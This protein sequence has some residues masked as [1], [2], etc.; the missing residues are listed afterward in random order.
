MHIKFKY[1]LYSALV[2]AMFTS[3]DDQD[4][5]SNKQASEITFVSGLNTRLSQDGGQWVA[6]DQIGIYMVNTGTTTATDYSN[7]PYKAESSAQTTAF[8]A[9]DASIYY[10]TDQS[11][12]D[13]IAYYP[14]AA[15]ITNWTYPVSL[16]NQSTGSAA[17]DLLYAKADN[18]GSGFT[19]GSVSFAFNHSLSKIILN[20]VDEDNKP[21]TPD[22]DGVR[23]KGMNTTADFDLKTGTLGTAATVADIAPYASESAFHAV[24]L[25]TTIASGHEVAIVVEGNPYR[26]NMNSSHSG[27][28]MKAGS[29]YTFKV[30]VKTSAAEVEAVLVDYSD[31]SITPWGDGGADNKEE[32]PTADLDIPA[33]YEKLELQNGES[34]KSALAGATGAKV[35]IVLADGGSY[36]ESGG[37]SIPAS[38]TSLIIAGKGG[39]SMP[40]VNFGGTM[41]LSGNMDLFKVYN[42]D[43]SGVYGSS[44]FINQSTAV[45]IGEI[46]FESCVIH[47]IRG[48]IRLQKEA[49]TLNLYKITDCIIYNINNYSLLAVEAE[50]IAPNV[51]M[52]KSTVYNVSGR[53]FNISGTT[54]PSKATIDQCTFN[55]GPKYAIVQFSSTEGADGTLIFTNNIVG[56]PFDST[57]GVSVGSYAKATTENGNYYV[58]DTSWLNDNS[59]GT[60]CGFTA[61]QLFADPDNG[62]FTQSKLTAGDPRWY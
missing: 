40:T 3:C 51:E 28:E 33:D 48:I 23:I 39:T 27:L 1:L 47:D 50:S 12:V 46:S 22:T 11:A 57:R 42:L 58:S 20:L 13:F 32:T 41:T 36:S 9:S 49:S 61:A 6:N 24:L 10:P 60:D 37:F 45:T 38:I 5:G 8:K 62:N 29:S 19:S 26:W 25:P 35:A 54:A 53:V 7:V 17:H 18:S 56:L 15:T 14:Y 52:T 44:Y 2:A 34:I 16:A 55:Q 31:N 4:T 43:F 21:L 59:V 30:T